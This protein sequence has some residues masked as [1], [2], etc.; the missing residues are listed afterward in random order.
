MTDFIWKINTLEVLSEY[1]NQQNVVFRATYTCIGTE[2]TDQG[3]AFTSQW[4]GKIKLT[5]SVEE[6]FTPYEQLTEQQVLGWLWS[7]GIDKADIESK[8]QIDIN[9]QKSPTQKELPLPW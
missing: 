6:N 5:L 9:Y 7:Q 4:V 2:S 3:T 8:V 1:Q